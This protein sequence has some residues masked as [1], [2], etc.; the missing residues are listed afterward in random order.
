MFRLGLFERITLSIPYISQI[1]NTTKNERMLPRINICFPS[2][3]FSNRNNIKLIT[4]TK[5]NRLDKPIK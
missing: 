3:V 2:L 5:E 4:K 1:N